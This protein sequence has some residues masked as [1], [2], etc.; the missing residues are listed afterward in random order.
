M[1]AETTERC[2]FGLFQAVYKLERLYLRVMTMEEP[3]VAAVRRY[4]DDLLHVAR[5][6]GPFGSLPPLAEGFGL[7]FG[8]ALPSLEAL[9]PLL[10][11]KA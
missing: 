3:A 9:S 4:Q 2:P 5:L 1:A 11:P 8:A 7:F 6:T 10:P